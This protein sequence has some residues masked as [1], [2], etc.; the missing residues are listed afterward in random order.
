MERPTVFSWAQ[1]E[2]QPRPPWG[3]QRGTFWSRLHG[4][5]GKVEQ[6]MTTGWGCAWFLRAQWLTSLDSKSGGLTHC[7]QK[8][9]FLYPQN[10]PTFTQGFVTP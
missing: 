8:S 10:Q 6:R 7:L 1:A 5:E 3:T 2:A 9:V 4:M